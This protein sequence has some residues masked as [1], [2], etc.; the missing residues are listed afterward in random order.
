MKKTFKT[1]FLF[2]ATLVA[3]LAFTSCGEEVS[4]DGPDGPDVDGLTVFSQMPDE[5]TRTTMGPNGLF[6][7][8]AITSGGAVTRD[9]IWI[10]PTGTTG[11]SFSLKSAS[12]EFEADRR[13]GK[14]YFNAP[15][16][17]N[18]YNLSYTG[19]GSSSGDQVTIAK[20]QRQQ[21]WNNSDHIGTSGDCA[22]ATA[23]K[24]TGTNNYTFTLNHK[25]A[26]LLFQ[27][28]APAA[29]STNIYQL[30]EITITDTDGNP[31]CGIF[32]LTMSG[33]QTS[34]ATYPESSH[35]ISLLCGTTTTGLILP[36]TISTADPTA[37]ST[38]YAVMLPRGYRNLRVAYTV[39][40]TSD[41][42]FQVYEDISG[43]YTANSAR[44]VQHEL[45]V[46]VQGPG[47]PDP[48]F[49]SGVHTTPTF[50]GVKF[51]PAFLYRTSGTATTTATLQLRNMADDPFILL[52]HNQPGS[53][54]TG[55][56]ITEQNRRMFFTWNELAEI[57]GHAAQ[58]QGANYNGNITKMK[59]IGDKSYRLPTSGEYSAL[60][61][62]PSTGRATVNYYPASFAA[63]KVD[64]SADANY[65][66]K[67]WDHTKAYNASAAANY[68]MGY[69]F[70]P[71]NMV[72]RASKISLASLNGRWSTTYSSLTA[73]E[74]K[75]FTNHGCMFLPATGYSPGSDWYYRGTNGFYWSGTITVND[76]S[77]AGH[78][79]FYGSLLNA[80]GT[81]RM[82]YFA[83]VPVEN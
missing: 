45:K 30:T 22:T 40:S 6:Y 60:I 42:V 23:T 76:P 10:D 44:L 53:G 15:L 31:L 20:E 34:G 56:A 18:S 51:K 50:G 11:T 35:V 29:S 71:D 77:K 3:A 68:I 32:P 52:Q 39:R 82:S 65:S 59:T 49:V 19:F 17:Q 48:Y 27:P 25:S 41:G 36:S 62:T 5:G 46:P 61:E 54:N 57:F 69:L 80:V 37:N 64:L 73:A 75:E 38:V 1:Q 81:N 43:T 78:F 12:S 28:Y 83:A 7:W 70:F 13:T 24:V 47:D 33:L 21:E 72:V 58:G 2:A 9:Q 63:V 55:S 66:N 4:I 79:G 67:G 8:Q 14:F 74:L 16:G 26:Y